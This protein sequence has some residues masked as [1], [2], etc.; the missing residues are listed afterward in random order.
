MFYPL[1]QHKIKT[2]F[3]HR[4]AICLPRLNRSS[5]ALESERR[6]VGA[7]VSDNPDTRLSVEI[8]SGLETSQSK[9]F[10]LSRYG[11]LMGVP[12]LRNPDR[13]ETAMCK[14]YGTNLL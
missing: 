6:D 5:S 10:V 12:E 14:S 1:Q 4:L 2:L 13:S 9:D 3:F 7:I 8:C 11:S